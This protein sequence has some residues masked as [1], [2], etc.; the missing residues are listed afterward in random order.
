M[1]QRRRLTLDV[2]VGRL[3][4]AT[5]EVGQE[6]AGARMLE[7]MFLAVGPSFRTEI[8]LSAI[9]GVDLVCVKDA[10]EPFD[11]M[12]DCDEPQAV[13][14]AYARSAAGGRPLPRGAA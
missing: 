7:L 8:A 11:P 14:D 3:F 5:R 2:D 6:S 9:Y 12:P 4:D 10:P 1:A 13:A